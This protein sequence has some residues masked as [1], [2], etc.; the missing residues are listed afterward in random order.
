M[1]NFAAAHRGPIPDT[2]M[3][4]YFTISELLASATADRL[5]ISNDPPRWVVLNL[6][7]LI[8]RILDPLRLLFG[9]PIYVNSGYRS[10]PVNTAVGGVSGSQHC[11]GQAADIR[12]RTP[13][14]TR[15]LWL[16][17]LDSGLPFDQLINEKPDASGTPS[18]IHISWAPK[19][20]RQV[21]SLGGRTSKR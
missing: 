13:E 11:K 10:I 12:G 20:R 7:E 6:E 2:I 4:Q 8:R 18:W 15:R 14:E 9:A 5:C 3:L 19:P 1:F 16:L 17:A 21:L